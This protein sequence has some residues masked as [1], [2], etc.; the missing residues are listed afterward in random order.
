MEI[1]KNIFNISV[2]GSIIFLIF[3]ILK[4]LTKKYFNSSWHYRML[5]LILIF[6]IVPAGGFIKI[7]A[8]PIL[9]IP[10]IKIQEFRDS[11]NMIK[12][13]GA[14]PVQKSEDI[15]GWKSEKEIGDKIENESPSI[16]ENKSHVFDK[17]NYNID[18]YT[19]IFQYIWIGGMAILF[20][21]KIVPYI[22]F[23]STILKNSIEIEN[24]NI[25]SLFDLCRN[26]LNI[27]NKISLRT[28][29]I[30]G[31]PMLMGVFRPIV[32]IPNIGNNA[33]KLKMIFLHELNHYKRKDILIKVF[34]FIVNTIHWFN[35]MIYILLNRMDRYCEYSIDERVVGKMS[36]EDRKHYG[37]I[38]LNLIDN[39]MMRK[40]YLTTAMGAGG[41]ELKFRLENMLFSFKTTRK[42]YIVSLLVSILIIVSGLT[43]ACN[44]VPGNVAGGN[45]PFAVYLKEDGLYYSH[46]SNGEETRIHEGKEFGHPLIS[47]TGDYVAYIKEKDICIY[48]MKNGGYE[49]IAEKSVHFDNFYDWIDGKTIIYSDDGPGF[50]IYNAS[51]KET[52]EHLDEYYYE[53]FRALNDNIVYGKKI[54]KWTD[55]DGD[56]VAIK[57][58]VEIDLSDYSP[59]DKKF[60]IETAIEAKKP[61]GSRL[62]YNPTISKVSEDRRYVFIMEKFASGSTSADYAGIGLY[63]TKEKIHVDF[64]DIYGMEGGGLAYGDEG[65]ELVVLPFVNNLT[66]NPKNRNLIGVIKGGF[67]EKFMNKEVILLNINDDKTYEITN[68]MNKD[69]VAMTPSF[70][71]DGEKLLY[72]ATKSVDPKVIT[73]FNGAYRVWESQPHNIYEYDI[74]SSETKKVTESEHFDFMPVGIS[75]NAILFCRSED[76]RIST[77]EGHHSLIKLINGKEEVLV[78]N[79]VINSLTDKNI[80]IF[81]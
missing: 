72:S 75:G 17:T 37:E 46:L 69:L 59:E 39:S 10:A 40:G 11:N 50:K 19:N 22:K 53:N 34:G 26:E 35:P 58:I 29:D 7:P 25:L 66:V 44:I 76:V 81:L 13:E 67:R 27:N 63:D 62:G 80:D 15:G 70:T 43:A 51:T 9:N 71:L 77:G 57:A 73:D 1:L 64:T 2:T 32:L 12:N 68:F 42:R 38:I 60:G 28:C 8:K 21:L 52:K 36:M 24:E 3:L 33:E 45:E 31:S 20:L 78:D 5:I 56:F 30:I 16:T 74:K 55:S 4:P 49:K 54:D 41:R 48:D 14:K 65:E 23:R 6:F 61:E 18:S 79:I 47:K